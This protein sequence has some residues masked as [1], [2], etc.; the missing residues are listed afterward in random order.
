MIGF[1]ALVGAY[2]TTGQIIPYILMDHH[3]TKLL[4]I[5]RA[6]QWS[7]CD[8]WSDYSAQLTMVYSDGSPGFF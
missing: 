2:A 5:C 4:E 6:N 8:A 7:S 3:I 1:V